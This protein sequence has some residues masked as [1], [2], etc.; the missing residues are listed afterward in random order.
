MPKFIGIYGGTFD[1]V[2]LGHT[3]AAKDIQ[4]ALEMNEVRLV[5][6]AQPPHRGNPMLT[7]QER[8]ALLTLAVANDECLIADNR[9]MLRTGPSYMV[10]TLLA[11]RKEMAPDTSLALILGMEAFNGVTQWHQWRQLLELA[12]IVVTDRAGFDNE[13]DESNGLLMGLVSAHQTFDKSQLKRASHGKIF[14]QNVTALDIS[15]TTIRSRIQRKQSVK[16][17]LSPAVWAVIERCDMYAKANTIK[18]GTLLK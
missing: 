2:H 12:H 1:P 5:L 4:V 17:L 6:S 7:A 15:A 18:Q 3:S 16:H 11:M 8:F 10:D 9:E 14:R 13:F